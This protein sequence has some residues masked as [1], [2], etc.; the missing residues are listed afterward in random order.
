MWNSDSTSLSLL[1]SEVPKI[2]SF[3]DF[4]KPCAAKVPKP[5]L[6]HDVVQL[7][8]LTKIPLKERPN[9]VHEAAVLE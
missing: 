9:I 2:H 8:A 4:G 7:L 3:A 6:C 1:K 5:P